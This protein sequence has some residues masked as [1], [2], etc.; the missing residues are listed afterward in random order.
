MPESSDPLIIVVSVTKSATDSSKCKDYPLEFEDWWID[1]QVGRIN[2]AFSE[3]GE[4]MPI[5]TS[6]EEAPEG[7]AGI[8]ELIECHS[9]ADMQSTRCLL[10]LF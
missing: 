3:N 6:A 9:W 8:R 2:C 10:P 4:E 1:H 5:E 7:I